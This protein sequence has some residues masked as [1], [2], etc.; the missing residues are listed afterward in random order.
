MTTLAQ[1]DFDT[2]EE[3][4]RTVVR[5]LPQVL[6]FVLILVVGYFVARAL[7]T[8]L[9]RVLRRVGFD[10]AVERGGVGRALA[11]TRYEPSDLLSR[12]VF[13]GLMLFVLQLAFGVFGDNPV[14][15][16]IAGV[17]AYL[18]DIFVAIVIIV[19]S[20][21]IAAGVRELVEASL[22]GLPYGRVL[23][24][25]AA[26]SIVVVGVFAALDQLDVAQT[27]VNALFIALLA[28]VAGSVIVAVGGSGIGPLRAYWE[29]ALTRLDDEGPRLREQTRGAAERVRRRAAERAEAEQRERAEALARAE[30]EADAQAT[31]PRQPSPTPPPPPPSGATAAGVVREPPSPVRRL[32]GDP[33]QQIR[34]PGEP[35]EPRFDDDTEVLRTDSGHTQPLRPPGEEPDDRRPGR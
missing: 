11:R 35:P 17:I 16:L 20:A 24:N 19:V 3:F 1:A 4:G 12:L 34:R 14:S 22:G 10:R 21:A 30:A 31:K 25:V 7:S 32:E 15:D 13:Y 2:L 33:T 26:G 28:M 5:V 29:R 6:L 27:V 18:P 23:A 9:D 8:V